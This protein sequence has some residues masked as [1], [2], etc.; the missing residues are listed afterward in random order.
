MLTKFST[1]DQAKILITQVKHIDNPNEYH[2][3]EL[4]E[5]LIKEQ[6]T[7]DPS[8]DVWALGVGGAMAT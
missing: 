8:V 7:V 6:T 2:A 4:C 1:N 5:I 3:P